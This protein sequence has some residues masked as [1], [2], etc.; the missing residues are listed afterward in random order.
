MFGMVYQADSGASGMKL[1]TFMSLPLLGAAAIQAALAP[2]KHMIE[3]EDFDAAQGV[4]LTQY[5]ESIDECGDGDWAR[6]DSVN[7]DIAS[8]D[9]MTVYIRKA[10][11]QGRIEVRLDARD[12]QPVGSTQL[13]GISGNV[14]PLTFAIAKTTGRHTVFLH[15]YGGDD[16]AEVNRFALT[17]V[18]NVE[19]GSRTWYVSPAGDDANDGQSIDTPFRTIRQA[20]SVMTAGSRCLIRE[21]IYRETIRPVFTGTPGAPIVYEAYNGENALISACE[22]LDD[23]SHHSGAIYKTRMA[24]SMSSADRNQIFVDGAMMALARSPNIGGPCPRDENERWYQGEEAVFLNSQCFLDRQDEI[25]PWLIPALQSVGNCGEPVQAFSEATSFPVCWDS[26][27]SAATG[28]QHRE[29][30]FFAG[31]ILLAY[32]SP[33]W[34]VMGRILA[35]EPTDL[36]SGRITVARKSGANQKSPKGKGGFICDLYGLLDSPGE[37]YWDPRDS[38][39]YLWCPDGD[40]PDNHL[41]EAKARVLAAD[42][43]AKSAIHLKGLQTVGGSM[44]LKNAEECVIDDCHFYYIAHMY[45]LEDYERGSYTY[46]SPYDPS[47]GYKGIYISGK[48]NVFTNSTVAYSAGSGVILDGT[49]NEVRNCRIHSCN[50]VGSYD[51]P[52][53]IYNNRFSERRKASGERNCTGQRILHNTLHGANRSLINF[54]TAGNTALNPITIQY[55]EFHT[56]CLNTFEGAAIYTYGGVGKGTECSH[57]WFHSFGPTK[58]GY[59][60]F[61]VNHAAWRVHHNVCWNGRPLIDMTIRCNICADTTVDTVYNN[62]IID[63]SWGGQHWP[64]EGRGRQFADGGINTLYAGSDPGPWKFADPGKGRYWLTEGSPAIDAGAVIPGLVESYAGAAPDLGAYEYGED[65]WI[66]GADWEEKELTYPPVAGARARFDAGAAAYAQR[67]PRIR[68]GQNRIVIG[69][70]GHACAVRVVTI[71]GR[72]VLR[73][74]ADSGESLTLD[75]RSLARG[76]YIVHVRSG[77]AALVKKMAVWR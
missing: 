50:Y 59:I 54:C 34:S 46:G 61:D 53:F 64:R 38:T 22:V 66:P 75:S 27:E 77:H 7:F 47:P 31:G 74:R 12:S 26:Y 11:A 56:F 58:C 44:T 35:S 18:L 51:A 52:I 62:T 57:N 63:S 36:T 45:L 20:S 15:F 70:G 10:S 32:A 8:F 25:F 29:R 37:W 19:G 48:N 76:H 71:Q 65:P 2:V 23:W 17:G 33:W 1:V 55:N 4:V 39:V 28:L 67:P 5:R 60:A 68:V 30:D 42:L 40:N 14:T 9:S 43:T 13:R 41:V 3:A 6:Y 72:T 21:G 69:A 49:D 16:V 24:W 73:A